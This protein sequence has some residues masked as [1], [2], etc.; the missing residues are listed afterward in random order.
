MQLLRFLPAAA[1]SMVLCL[2][3]NGQVIQQLPLTYTMRTSS[4]RRAARLRPGLTPAAA[5][6]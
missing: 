6:T 3:A 5:R 4:V 2:A 1:V